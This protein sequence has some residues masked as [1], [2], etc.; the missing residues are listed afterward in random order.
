MTSDRNQGRRCPSDHNRGRRCPSDHNRGCQVY[1]ACGTARRHEIPPRCEIEIRVRVQEYHYTTRLTNPPSPFHTRRRCPSDRFLGAR[2]LRRLRRAGRLAAGLLADTA[3]G[4]ISKTIRWTASSSVSIRWTAGLRARAAWSGGNLTNR[5]PLTRLGELTSPVWFW[6]F[7]SSCAG[8]GGR[9]SVVVH[10]ALTGGW[11][12]G[13]VNTP[14]RAAGGPGPL[15]RRRQ[16]CTQHLKETRP[17]FSPE[18]KFSSRPSTFSHFSPLGLGVDF[19]QPRERGAAFS[20][21]NPILPSILHGV[22]GDSPNTHCRLREAGPPSCPAR[23]LVPCRPPLPGSPSSHG[24]RTSVSSPSSVEVR[25][26]MFFNDPHRSG[27]VKVATLLTSPQL[28]ELLELRQE[29]TTSQGEQALVSN[30]CVLLR[31]LLTTY[32]YYYY[33]YYYYQAPRI[34]PPRPPADPPLAQLC[35]CLQVL[36]AGGA[37]GVQQL[38]GPGLGYGRDAE[39]PVS[40]SVCRFSLP[41]ARRAFSTFLDLD[42]DMDGMLSR[43]ELLAYGEGGLTRTFVDALFDEHVAAWWGRGGKGR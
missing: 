8:N 21:D 10:P 1:H 37:A 26:L 16:G 30:W 7:E 35:I 42:S 41:A 39:P 19:F 6:F 14:R 18:V 4:P 29:V 27:R 3:A 33:C 43:E 32:Y 15:T 11:A 24:C 28:A 20:L 25:K 34:R 22:T 9:G 12:A 36:A 13:G 5:P 40:V 17:L 31:L 38:P 2:D 23:G